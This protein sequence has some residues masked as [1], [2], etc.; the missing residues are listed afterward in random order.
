M[1]EEQKTCPRC[2]STLV[3]R[4][5]NAD[6]CNQCSLDFNLDRDP[7]G[8]RAHAERSERTGWKRSQQ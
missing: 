1:P 5:A 7:V 3:V 6:H 2:G 4:I 8:T